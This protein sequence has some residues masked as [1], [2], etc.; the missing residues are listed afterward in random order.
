MKVQCSAYTAGYL[1]R[2]ISKTIDCQ[3]CLQTYVSSSKE[4]HHAYIQY[5]E[6]KRLKHNNLQY[7]TEMFLKLYREASVMIHNFLNSNCFKRNVGTDLHCKLSQLRI[8]WL[9]CAE[10]GNIVKRIFLTTVI[11]LHI[12]NW[13]NIIN[14]I[15]KG[16]I[17]EK[18]A[19]KMEEPQKLA[20][21]KYKTHKLR[22]RTLNK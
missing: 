13:C 16:D 9:G 8:S 3:S 20:Y 11:K 1:C 2:K 14:K 17:E 18:Y 15:L 10:H 22:Q 4:E 5:R 12:H 7:P 21:K 19:S 6:Y